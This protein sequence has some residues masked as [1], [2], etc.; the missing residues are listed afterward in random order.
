MEKEIFRRSDTRG[1]K[2]FTLVEVLITLLIV[3]ILA[4]IS[5]PIYVGQRTKAQRA[6][7]KENLE[8][9]RLLM[10]QY[11]NE[12]GCYYKT[13]TTPVCTDAT[14]SGVTSLQSVF[15]GFKPGTNLRFNYVITTANTATTYVIGAV[16]TSIVSSG[17]VSATTSGIVS[18]TSCANSELKVDNNN[19]RCGF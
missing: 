4:A 13:G 10:E 17:S 5:V 1:N 12:N 16:D 3:G 11:F 19:N 2:G 7:A 15:P 14:V 18:A 8:A 6:E 9:L